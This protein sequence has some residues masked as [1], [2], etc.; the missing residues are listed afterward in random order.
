MNVIEA[1]RVM[2]AEDALTLW[3][4]TPVPPLDPSL[5]SASVPTI[6]LLDG[7]PIILL[8][9]LDATD[10]V[11]L[12]RAV[13]D[14]PM[15]TVLRGAGIRSAAR[16]FGFVAANTLLKRNSCRAA[17]G[18]EQ[19]PRAHGVICA[20]AES[21]ARTLKECLPDQYRVNSEAASAIRSEWKLPGGLWTSGVVNWTASLP[22]HRDRNNL[23]AWSVMPVV[24]RSVRGGHLHFPELALA[25]GDPLVAACDDG[26]VLYFNGQQ[27]M[28]GVTPTQRVA[29]DG[30]R[31]SCVYY[32]VKKMCSCLSP[33]EE[34]ERGRARRTE[35]ESTMVERHRAQG[36]V[37]DTLG[38]HN[39][40]SYD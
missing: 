16:V 17:N 6:V 5:K 3:R 8:S 31:I 12:R 13:L 18:A 10:R 27:Y 7:R 19:A 20:T 40:E 14:Y 24:R 23:D 9:R 2:G 28:H 4:D 26:D 29:A 34:Y 11:A 33:T 22:Y 36:Y 37:A 30:Y 25:N 38:V 15:D 35:T 21:L 32:P 1:K 39:D